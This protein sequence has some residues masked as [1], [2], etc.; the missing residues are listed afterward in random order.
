[1]QHGVPPTVSFQGLSTVVPIMLNCGR[2]AELRWGR[3]ITGVLGELTEPHSFACVEAYGL[4]ERSVKIGTNRCGSHGPV[5]MQPAHRAT[6]RQLCDDG[7][8]TVRLDSIRL[9]TSG[10]RPKLPDL[11]VVGHAHRLDLPSA[12]PRRCSAFWLADIAGMACA[13]PGCPSRPP[14]VGVVV[15]TANWENVRGGKQ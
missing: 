15:P 8:D 11:Q 1:M 6:P 14:Q 7:P 10:A 3:I 12:E 13:P 4:G 2:T 5:A 9:P